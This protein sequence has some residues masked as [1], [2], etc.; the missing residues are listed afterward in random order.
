MNGFPKGLQFDVERY[1]PVTDPVR[2]ETLTPSPMLMESRAETTAKEAEVSET[3][4]KLAAS[5]SSSK[6][7]KRKMH[8][9]N[10][11]E[12]EAWS[13]EAND[14]LAEVMVGRCRVDPGF[15]PLT[16]RLLS[17]LETN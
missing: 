16:P 2:L 1:L 3:E 13:S 4:A 15:S 14:L 7:G 12:Q 6:L 9:A 11:R 10:G 8:C 17:A 5:G